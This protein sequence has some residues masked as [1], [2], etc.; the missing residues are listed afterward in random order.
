MKTVSARRRQRQLVAVAGAAA[1]L[2]LS[3]CGG[4]S[5]G[6]GSTGSQTDSG[7]AITVWVDPPRVPAAEAFK[8]AYP[9]IDVKINQIDG[10]VGGK[11]LQQQF[12]QFNQAKKG[13]PDAIFFPSND[14]IAWAS[15]PQVKYTA[16]L[17]TIMKDTLSGYDSAVIAP[18]SNAG[19]IEC[20]RND[21]APDV[22]WYNAKFFKA[23]GYAVPTT[24]EDYATLSVKIAKEHPGKVSGFTGDAYAPDRYLWASGC[25]TNDKTSATAVR[26]AL[27]DPTCTR[28]KDLLSTMVAGKSLSSLGIFDADATKTGKDMVMSPG[29]VWWGDYLFRQTWKIPAGQMTAVAPLTWKGDSKPSTGDEGGG[30]WGASSHI[31][32]KELANTL[33]FMKFVGTDPRWQVDLS[34]GLPGYGPVQ[35]AWIA[36]QAKQNYFADN[37]TTFDA[38]KT[39]LSLVPDH[40]AYMLYNTGSVWTETVT[41][42]LTSG[43]SFDDAWKAFGSDLVNQAKSVGYTVSTK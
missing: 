37:S 20:L 12:S 11:G 30:L 32:G 40:H 8:K 23:N 28:A 21:A 26:I 17:S 36:K 7:G 35:D 43:K 38:A 4:S 41:P 9:K 18:C 10:T 25:P 34:T 22:F 16:D 39:A 42:A 15:S 1:M 31:K 2:A 33:T 6:G 13:W 3:A 29:A 5:G 19:R 14:D 24:W 27:D